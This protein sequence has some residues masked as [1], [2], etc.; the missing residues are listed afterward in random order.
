MTM[1]L[2]VAFVNDNVN[3]GCEQFYFIKVFDLIDFIYLH[4]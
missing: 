3:N 1:A 2:L 4:K